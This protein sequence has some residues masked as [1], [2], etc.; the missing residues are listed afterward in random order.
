MLAR[1]LEVK[2]LKQCA[3]KSHREDGFYRKKVFNRYSTLPFTVNVFTGVL[4]FDFTVNCFV[5]GPFAA[6][7]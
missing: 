7:L 6:A 5:N 1:R 3:Q 4:V 2:F